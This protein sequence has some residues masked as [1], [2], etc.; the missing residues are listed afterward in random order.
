MLI[1]LAPVNARLDRALVADDGIV[2]TILRLGFKDEQWNATVVDGYGRHAPRS[3][4]WKYRMHP[5]ERG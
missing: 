1:V 4:G 3:V 2:L 5:G